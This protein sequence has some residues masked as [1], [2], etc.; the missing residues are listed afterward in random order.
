[1][2]HRENTGYFCFPSYSVFIP[3]FPSRPKLRA[4]DSKNTSPRWWR[5][6]WFWRQICSARTVNNST[7]DCSELMD[8][9]LIACSIICSAQ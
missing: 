2:I 4:Q 5:Q 1:M 7:M 9:S 6:V 8:N 3:R